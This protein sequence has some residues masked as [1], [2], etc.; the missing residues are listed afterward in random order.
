[1]ETSG[2]PDRP[3][4]EA[5]RLVA[6]W[7]AGP[8]SRLLRRAQIG[9]RTCVLDLG[10]GHGIVAG[11]LARRTAGIVV[12][13]DSR[14][15]IHFPSEAPKAWWVQGSAEALPFHDAAFDLI[16]AENTLLWVADLC[17][18]LAEAARV[19]ASGGALVALEPD[20]GGML[21]WPELGLRKLWLEGLTRAGADPLVGRKLPGTLEAL[22]LEV[23]CELQGIPQPAQSDAARLLLDLPLSEDER[24]RVE[25]SARAL[26]SRRGRWGWLLHVPYVMVVAIRRTSDAA[27]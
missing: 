12:G 14:P 2:Q 7:L 11:E 15:S 24:A 25:E 1:M 8:R 20:Y 5:S 27:P 23:W 17:I 13:L 6:R 21:E 4:L 3:S 10:C 22:G 19:L 9:Q 26:D 16:L 18:T